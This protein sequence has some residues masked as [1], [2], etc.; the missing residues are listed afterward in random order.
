MRD[1][2]IIKQM[3]L[4]GKSQLDMSRTL[5]LRRE[6]V[7]RKISRWTK[8]HDFTEWLAEAWL[9]KYNKVD[10]NVAFNALTK[11]LC[12]RMPTKIESEHTETIKEIKISWAMND[13]RLLKNPNNKVHTTSEPVTISQK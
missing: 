6:T 5:K 3:L 8:T 7:N 10:D 11:L 1:L 4:E 13:D 12:K 9:D 2:T